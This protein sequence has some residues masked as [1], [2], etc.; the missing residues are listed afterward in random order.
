MQDL[1]VLITLPCVLVACLM[2]T[3]ARS[4]APPEPR[5]PKPS[6][7]KLFN[8][9]DLTG[10]KVAKQHDFQRAGKVSVQDQQ[11]ILEKGRPAT[12]IVCVKKLPRT[13][14][15]VTL[16]AKRIAG[17]DFFCGLTFPVDQGYCSLILGGWGGGVTGL[18]NIDNMSAV[19]NETTD[20]VK[21]KQDRWY[22]LRLRVTPSKIE[23]WVDKRQIVEVETENRK[24]SIWWEQEPMR[25]FGIA[26]WNTKAALR[27][28]HV[29][30]L[31]ATPK[32]QAAAPATDK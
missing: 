15:E 18:S 17:E 16:Q 23:A 9:K 8:G 2:S 22:H 4:E 14:Y 6:S 12:G 13:N 21:F 10:W 3:P 20:F 11:I 24:F 1:R 7:M 30:P 28:I 31:P 25:P 26:S 5:A 27:D 19:E 29:K 32:T